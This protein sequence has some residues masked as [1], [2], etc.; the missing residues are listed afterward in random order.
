[1][2]PQPERAPDGAPVHYG[3]RRPEQTKLYQLVQ[4]HA[5]TFVAETQPAN[6]TVHPQFV[7]DAFD[8]LLECGSLAHGVLG[9]R[10]G[11][12]HHGFCLNRSARLQARSGTCTRNSGMSGSPSMNV[13]LLFPLME[14]RRT[15]WSNRSAT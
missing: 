11:R 15:R 7:K 10:C 6:A 1:M 9:L 8:A 5:A 14:K 13:P 3:R 12:L 4:P 2:G